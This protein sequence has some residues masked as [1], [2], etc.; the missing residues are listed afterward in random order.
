VVTYVKAAVIKIKPQMLKKIIC[1]L[2]KYRY[3][4]EIQLLRTK[5]K[6]LLINIPQI[7]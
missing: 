4:K 3:C 2:P 5:Y 1:Y 7:M 6:D